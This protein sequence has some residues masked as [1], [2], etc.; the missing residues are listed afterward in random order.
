MAS[1]ART[2]AALCTL[3]CATSAAL[4]DEL[5]IYGTATPV[6]SAGGDYEFQPQATAVGPLIPYFEVENL[7]GWA[8]FDSFNGHISGL[9]TQSDVGTYQDIQVS[10]TDGESTATL[11]AFAIVVQGT[12]GSQ[13]EVLT[14]QPPTEN[15]DGTPLTDLQGY[16]VYEGDSPD[17]LML[18]AYSDATTPSS[19]FSQLTAGTH[20]FAVS[21]LNTS[22]VESGRSPVL[23][24]TIL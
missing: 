2:V 22:H 16:Y 24:A 10:I 23:A 7:P 1:R 18:V 3:A 17:T 14:W 11:P 15:V 9:P 20:Y 21:A 19:V 5:T 6:V 8:T 13:S 4:G 12:D